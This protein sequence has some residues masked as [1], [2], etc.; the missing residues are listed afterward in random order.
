MTNP[1]ARL[2]TIETERT[3]EKR[4][5]LLKSAT[6]DKTDPDLIVGMLRD[7]DYEDERS[8]TKAVTSILKRYPQLATDAKPGRGSL[9]GGGG[10]GGPGDKHAG[11][12]NAIRQA[13]GRG[14]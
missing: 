10:N 14:A 4:Q 6:K 9:P 2:D 8:M 1:L 7:E 12:N 3:G 13:A 5:S 11:M